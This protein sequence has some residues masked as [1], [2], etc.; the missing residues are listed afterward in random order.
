M[1]LLEKINPK[2]TA[3]LVIDIQKDFVDPEGMLAKRG[4]DMS[5][6]NDVME[7]LP[8]FLNE[9]K[10]KDVLILYTQQVY[11]HDSLNSLQKEQYDLDGKFVTCDKNTDGYELYR[12]TPD[13]SDVY[14]KH[15]YNAFSN[16]K[17]IDK[18]ETN[19]IKTLIMV[20][21][22][23]IYC[24]ETAIR[25]GYDLGYKIVVPEDLVAGNAK[26]IEMHNNTLA[27][28]KKNYGVVSSS[29][30]ILNI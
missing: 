4:R 13:K 2:D 5:M 20:G 19:N 18:L 11:D 28:V 24:V 25:N 6:I 21:V 30:E 23:T 22:D 3:I 8:L 27:H 7:K 29:E 17:L 16:N 1:E 26:H 12:L 15:N 14:V 10:K 9:A